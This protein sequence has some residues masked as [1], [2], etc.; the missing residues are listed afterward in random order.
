MEMLGLTPWELAVG[1]ALFFGGLLV[2]VAV[3]GSRSARIRIR[4]LEA[5][6]QSANERHASYQDQVE[7]HFAQTS[8]LFGDLTRQ[9]REVWDHLAQ[10]ARELCADRAPGLARGFASPLL[11]NPTDPAPTEAG[12][13]D[14]RPAQDEPEG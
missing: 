7:K 13:D 9:Y 12:E 6:L 11:V 3:G 10:G 14:A 4:A 8:D 2:G 5:E 1:A